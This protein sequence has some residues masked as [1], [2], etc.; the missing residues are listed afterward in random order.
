MI[1]LSD[2]TL[3]ERLRRRTT[4]GRYEISESELV[5]NIRSQ[6]AAGNREGVRRLCEILLQRCMPTFQ[7]HSQGLRHRPD[8]REEAIAN[9]A[10]Q[11][12]REAQDPNELFITQNFIHY[13]R[14]LCADEFNRLLRQEGLIYRRDAEGRPSGRPQHVPR[15]LVETLRTTNAEDEHQ[16]ASDVADPRDQFEDLHA[17]D[18]SQRILN[19]LRDPLDRKIMTLRALESMK[20][21]DIALLC[22]KTERTVRLRY[23]RARGYLRDCMMREQTLSHSPAFQQHQ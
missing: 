23:E 22:Q 15:S 17:K 3:D 13:L 9:M 1:D 14:C 6:N 5:I 19:Y 8:L 16:P 12:L 7:R 4:E 10:E 20:W 21:D 2:P 11:V 18:E